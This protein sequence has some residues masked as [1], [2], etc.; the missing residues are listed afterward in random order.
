[1]LGSPCQSLFNLKMIGDNVNL[2]DP[3]YD[4][5]LG[6]MNIK[7]G[8]I[9]ENKSEQDV[10]ELRTLILDNPLFDQDENKVFTT[11]YLFDIMN[12]STDENINYYHWLRL[13]S[14]DEMYLIIKI[15]SSDNYND[16]ILNIRSD[17]KIVQ[18]VCKW[19]LK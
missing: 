6:L 13:S 5:K 7:C 16:A 17:S 10:K 8:T 12:K 18:E 19:R 1:M 11:K 15:I 2:R 4:R 3:N 14:D 9:P